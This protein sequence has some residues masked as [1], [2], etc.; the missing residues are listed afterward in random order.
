MHDGAARLQ[1]LRAE[2]REGGEL[3]GRVAAIVG[4]AGTA[5]DLLDRLAAATPSTAGDRV[6]RHAAG[7]AALAAWSF[8]EP[9]L[10][11]TPR[12]VVVLDGAI[13]NRRDLGTA[14]SDA[15]LIA[16]L[17][18]R[19]GFVETLRRLN[20]DF[21][22]VLYD[23]AADRLWAARDRVGAK[24][25]YWARGDGTIALASQPRP[26]LR[27]PGVSTALNRKFVALF[28]GS[29]YRCF[30]NDPERSPY[31]DVQQLPAAHYLE[32]HCGDVRFGRYWDLQQQPD[33]GGSENELAEQYRALLIDA[34]RMRLDG[35]TRPAFTLSG[36]M[37]SSTVLSCAVA[38]TGAKQHAWSSVYE[39]ATYDES[40]DIRT[41]LDAAVSEWHQVRIG[42]PDVLPTIRDMIAINDEPIA[43]ATWLSHYEL[44]RR[45]G[46]GGAGFATL[47]GGLGG[48]ELNA[49]E[50]EYFFFF[51][52]DLAA[53]GDDARLRHETAKWIE[54][55]DHPIFKKT[56]ELMERSLERLVDLRTPG[57]CLPDDARLLK[58]ARAVRP[59][60]W[61]VASFRPLMDHPFTSYLKNRTYQDIYRETAPCCLRA[62]DR[63]GAAFGLEIRWPFFDYRLMELMFRVPSTMKI[64]DGVTKHLLRA[65]TRDLVPEATRTRI[66]KTGWNA[67]A[68]LWFAGRNR[69]ALLDLTG[70]QRFRQRGIYDCAA[71][72]A[73]V[74]EH[75]QIV[76][77]GRVAENHMM[78]IW[79]LVNLEL[80][81]QHHEQ[82]AV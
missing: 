49:G 80:W 6:A 28:A 13:F 71:V 1:C 19:H 77:S 34:V 47:F 29:H 42:D 9:A 11:A 62:A 20:G 21:A 70:S 22:I 73:L 2:A 12:T 74:E 4:D 8:D 7:R 68:H 3:M 43:T 48:D 52:S 5:A 56:F 72:D 31:E 44:C 61:D 10:A 64:R 14:S 82:S 67:P 25:L 81:I 66:K 32:A 41:I 78:F 55:H 63:H 15:Q 18:E 65:A 26:L 36:G 58:Y 79:Q 60:Y 53:A 24:P 37:D 33:V 59:E 30:D 17:F 23:V 69:A 39:D 46:R 76:T 38:V 16:M 27:L 50:Y 75:H 35:A 45:A 57:R 51:F 40:A 54:Y